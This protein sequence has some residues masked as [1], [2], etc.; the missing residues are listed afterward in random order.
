MHDFT[1]RLRRELADWRPSTADQRAL[2]ADYER[3]LAEEHDAAVDRELGRAHVT[4]SAFVF[5]PDLGEV[6][7]CF[8][9]KAGFWLQLGGHI[10]PGDDSVQATALREAQ[11]EGG[12][13]RLDA[14]GDA[15]LDLDRHGL[16]PGFSRCDTHWDVGYG[17]LA[18]GTPTASDE[19]EAVQWWPVDALPAE[20][21]AGL[22]TR[23]RRAAQHARDASR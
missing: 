22:G 12:I 18:T 3:F 4:G 2:K 7:L 13:L 5:T 6:L 15:P 10:E 17:F 14:I 11:E 16:G 20:V 21:P 1:Q 19:S 9:R 8:H 23:V